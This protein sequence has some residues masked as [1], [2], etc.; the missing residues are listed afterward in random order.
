[1]RASRGFAQQKRGVPSRP[2]LF[3][4]CRFRYTRYT[5]D[6]WWRSGWGCCKLAIKSGLLVYIA[7]YP[8]LIADFDH[9]LPVN[10]AVSV[11]AFHTC[12]RF[13]GVRGDASQSQK[14][15]LVLF[16]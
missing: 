5:R 9:E 8:C 2:L 14:W 6:V 3:V 4:T 10:V 12:A 1:M 13:G 15:G 7:T 11:P 16:F